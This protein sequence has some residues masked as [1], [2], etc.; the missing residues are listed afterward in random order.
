MPPSKKTM[1]HLSKKAM[2]PMKTVIISTAFALCVSVVAVCARADADQPGKSDPKPRQ[3]ST[4]KL[5][6]K[7]GD[8]KKISRTV[9][10]DMSDT[11]YFNPAKLTIQR[12]ETVRFVVKN[13]GKELHQM[14]IGTLQDLE[15]H[16]QLMAS[17]PGMVEHAGAF[18][19]Y[20]APGKTEEIV[21]QFTEN[22]EFNF[23]C[24]IPRHSK[25]AEV[26]KVFVVS[27]K[28]SAQ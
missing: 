2:I 25:A 28:S 23:G 7:A 8:P 10:V 1:M 9:Y 21:W 5:F 27:P 18:M 17:F 3:V 12:G 26:G 13:S 11:M 14:V 4:E 6:G 24:V 20:V 19:T 22:G 16:A 15:E